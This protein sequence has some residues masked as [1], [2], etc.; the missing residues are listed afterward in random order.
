MH[1]ESY[2]VEIGGK[3]LIAE[4]TD[5]ADQAH[6]SVIIRY[7]N[8]TVLA[9]A[10]M[11]NRKREGGDFF[12]LT[13]DFEERFYAAG[14]ILGSRFMRREGR[15]SDAAV[16]SGRI[17]DRTIRPLFDQRI[18][19]D[20]QVVITV[21]SIDKDEPD[22][23]AVNAASI[24][25]ITSNI[26]FGGP[27][28]AIRVA[29]QGGKWVTLPPFRVEEGFDIIEGD[30]ELFVC[31][32]NGNV[33]MI[34]MGGK[35]IA[36]DTVLEG[37]A[38]ASKEIE[39]LQKFQSEIIAKHGKA[40]RTIELAEVG[41]DIKKLF[42]EKIAPKFEKTIFAGVAGRADEYT[43]MAE[44]KESVKEVD[45]M[46]EHLAERYFD[47]AVNDLL[48]KKAIEENKRPDNRSFDEVRPLFAQAGGLSPVL[49][50]T[51]IFYRGGTHIL[52]ALTLGGPQDS[53]LVEGMEIQGKK[54]YMHHYNF[55]PFSNG[56]TG[57]MGGMNRRAI[58]HGALAEKALVPVLPEKEIFP[59]TI[60]IVSESMA[61]NGSTSMA[62]VCG[63]TLAL[64]DA[65][66]PIKE[67]V[68]G[69]ASGLMM[70]QPFDKTQG[71][72]TRYK[73]LTDIQGPEDHHGDMDF[74][75]AGTKNGVTAI[76]MDVKVDGIPLPILKE[77]FEKARAAR[78]KIL[79]V[80]KK[81]IA[82]PRPDIS[83]YA[84]KIVVIKIKPDQIGLV[85]GGGGKTV[86]E[87]REKTGAEI[88]IEDDG[89]VF[90]TGKGGSAEKA[91]DIIASMTHEYKSGEMFK[92]V[93]VRVV[94][95]GAFVEI[96]YN[97]EGL[98]HV[99]EIAPFRIERVSDY[100]KEGMEVPVVVKETDERGRISLSIKRADKDFI[101]P[102]E[103]D[104]K[105]IQGHRG[106]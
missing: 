54:R 26:P 52:S 53:Q 59:Y 72:K 81:E 41:D 56:E 93:V 74:K 106:Q 96:G 49:H 32:K 20:V 36:E 13:V 104:A 89:T 24:A 88:D 80:M 68:A 57:R 16:L 50:G 61:S 6:G 83:P 22:V 69:I 87:I 23:L 27:V 37:L 105:L 11:S 58:G 10:V 4:F 5:L 90:I 51:G 63:S 8:T 98:V 29:R 15:P 77:A 18:R 94:D 48:H 45:G 44:W 35:E 79:D 9:T 100:L 46:D 70:E 67:P 38:Y 33:N 65:G 40:K 103:R 102:N 2:E 55:P 60:R 1:T 17:I 14:Q 42:A 75:V 101:K 71:G 62:S 92:G 7:G 21:L 30:C 39:K 86:N 25:L 85:I 99:S 31:G 97:A 28:S 19:N 66:V 34:E 73:V 95:F 47:N 82:A 43:L 3:K 12:P 76:Q 84:P 64:M 78:L 91:R